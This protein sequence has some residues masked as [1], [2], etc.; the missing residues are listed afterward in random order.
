MLESPVIINEDDPEEYGEAPPELDWI[1]GIE[2]LLIAVANF[3]PPLKDRCE[4]L[5]DAL[6]TKAGEWEEYGERHIAFNE[7]EPD[8]EREGGSRYSGGDGSFSVASVFSD[9]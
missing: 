7:P 1:N 4:I 6:F 2:E 8:Y 3:S 9:L 5:I